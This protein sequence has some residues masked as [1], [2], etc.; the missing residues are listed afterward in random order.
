MIHIKDPMLG[1]ALFIACEY[2]NCLEDRKEKFKGMTTRDLIS[3]L[4]PQGVF[5][6]M[7]G[8][9]D[10]LVLELIDYFMNKP[11]DISDQLRLKIKE[12]VKQVKHFVT[13]ID[14]GKILCLA[15][16]V[17]SVWIERGIGDLDL[18]VLTDQ[19][20]F[21]TLV[22]RAQKTKA[23]NVAWTNGPFQVIAGSSFCSSH[24][25]WF[26]NWK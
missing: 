21:I 5:E 7:Q 16:T 2:A 19:D 20:F 18:G 26:P 1:F 8:Q 17:T 25:D 22:D 12:F 3:W 4:T 11:K 10:P 9:T 14:E 15:A 6:E 23:S 13:L 24:I